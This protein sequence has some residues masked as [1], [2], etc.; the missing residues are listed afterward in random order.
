MTDQKQ[1]QNVEYFSYLGSMIINYARYTCKIKS[2]IV[3]AKAAFS[4]KKTLFTSKSDLN[5]GIN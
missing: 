1:P 3:T 2:S 4:E 5:L